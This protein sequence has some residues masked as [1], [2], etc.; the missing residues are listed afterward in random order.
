MDCP[1]LEFEYGDADGHGAELAG[2]SSFW[3][4]RCYLFIG[5]KPRKSRWDGGWIWSGDIPAATERAGL[6]LEGHSL[7]GDT[8]GTRGDTGITPGP[9]GVGVAG[10]WSVG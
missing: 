3:A 8:E 5:K 2:E 10:G 4:L 6:L 9:P 7:L 1:N